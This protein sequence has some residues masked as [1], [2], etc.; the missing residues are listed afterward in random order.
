MSSDSDNNPNESTNSNNNSNESTDSA[1][2]HVFSDTDS[3]LYCHE[4]LLPSPTLVTFCIQE[5]RCWNLATHHLR[6]EIGNHCLREILWMK[7]VIVLVDDRARRYEN[8]AVKDV[9]KIGDIGRMYEKIKFDIPLDSC[10]ET[11]WFTCKRG[12]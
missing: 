7:S 10:G 2:S 6:R 3:D 12:Q 11:L 1:L 5:K 8:A 4:C 9:R